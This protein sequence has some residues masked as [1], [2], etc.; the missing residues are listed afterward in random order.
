M[1]PS[2]GLFTFLERVDYYGMKCCRGSWDVITALRWLLCLD[3]EQ[4]VSTATFPLNFN[5]LAATY[6][7]R[8]HE[9]LL[10]RFVFY[11][12]HHFVA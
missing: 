2:V 6:H 1:T 11:K 5:N 8:R 10:M 4:Q 9:L 3:H 7:T 12:W